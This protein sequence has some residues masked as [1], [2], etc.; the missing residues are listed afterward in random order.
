MATDPT[1]APKI[2]GTEFMDSYDVGGE[3][4][5]PPQPKVME[6]GKAKYIAFTAMA[7]PAEK[8]KVRDANDKPL[9]TQ[10]KYFKAIIEGIKLEGSGYEISQSHIGTAQ[11]KKYKGGQPTGEL[12]N[13]SPALD[14]LHAHGIDARPATVEEYENLFKATADRQFQ[15]TGEWSAWDKDAQTDVATKW[16]DFPEDPANPGQRLPYIERGGKRYWARLSV[17]RWVSALP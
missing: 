9:M 8:I 4:V 1:D 10:D 3:Y 12:R 7:P 17:K 5:P 14:Y 6:N 15:L 13:A 2:P 11:Y 16:E